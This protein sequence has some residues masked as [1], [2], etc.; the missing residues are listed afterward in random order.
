MTRAVRNLT[1]HFRIRGSSLRKSEKM[2]TSRNTFG[3]FDRNLT[4]QFIFYVNKFR[5]FG[6]VF[7]VRADS[8]DLRERLTWLKQ[9]RRQQRR[10]RLR[11]PPLRS[12]QR[13]PPLRS[14][15]PPKALPPAD[16]L[17]LGSEGRDVGG[18]FRYIVTEV[19]Y[20]AGGSETRH[21][22]SFLPEMIRR[23]LLLAGLH[24]T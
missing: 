7:F 19:L 11:R 4:R 1:C 3:A 12:R 18:F 2:R 13:R 21:R 14:V 16:L 17:T 10:H 8:N 15:K 23:R 24:L 20:K 6:H 5:E 22:S 9:Q